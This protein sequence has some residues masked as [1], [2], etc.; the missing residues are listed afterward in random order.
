MPRIDIKQA[1]F[2]ARVKLETSTET[3]E[4]EAQIL[5]GHVLG[6][7]RSYLYTWPEEILSDRH[8]EA[9]ESAINERCAGKPIA[10]ITG[11]K[12]FWSLSLKVTPE[13]LVPRPATESLLEE[14]LQR[15]SKAPARI[16]DLGTGSGALAIALAHERPDCQVT[17]VDISK[18]ALAIAKH[19]AD[20]LDIKNIEFFMGDWCAP[21]RQKQDAIMSNPPYIS[22]DD[23]HLENTDIKHE[24]L[25]ALASGADG[26]EAIRQITK[27]AK[28]HLKAGG[29]LVLE[30]GF[31]QQ[32]TVIETLVKNG[33]QNIS[34]HR[35]SDGLPRFVIGYR[36]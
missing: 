21:L 9:L 8:L 12:E 34:G 29:M 11:S 20:N 6:Q 4:L 26:L 30:H 16:A 32:P 19:N 27:D 22:E 25:Q 7:P 15:L 14:V 33:Y 2:D 28:D 1:L 3:P 23:P 10:Y 18:P 36:R 35:D 5:L 24:P 31:E 13:V 17:A